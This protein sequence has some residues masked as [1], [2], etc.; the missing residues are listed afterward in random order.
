MKTVRLIWLS[1]DTVR[2]NR[3][4]AEALGE[5]D[6]I[7]KAARF[8][9]EED[10]LL[11]LGGRYLIRRFVGPSGLIYKGPKGKTLA[12]HICFNLSHSADR[13]ALALAE[14]PVGLDLE[15]ELR[16]KAEFEEEL[17]AF[18]LK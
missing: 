4:K 6:D 5:P 8:V 7:R 3:K 13:I 17:R 15:K 11:F 16:Q 12:D 14:E 2:A 1:A 10:Q 18:L 9:R